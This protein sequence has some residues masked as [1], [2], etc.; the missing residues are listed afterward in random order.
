[1]LERDEEQMKRMQVLRLYQASTVPT[2]LDESF[3]EKDIE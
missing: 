2:R 3:D 1:M